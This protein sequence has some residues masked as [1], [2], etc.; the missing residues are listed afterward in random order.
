VT[1][2][3]V[4]SLRVS[5][6][7]QAMAEPFYTNHGISGRY[8]CGADGVMRPDGEA[9]P[10]PKAKPAVKTPTTKTTEKS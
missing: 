10:A 6:N 1:F 4:H 2:Q 7:R 9:V 5:G 8:V 3:S